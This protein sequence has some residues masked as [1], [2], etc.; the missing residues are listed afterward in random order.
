MTPLDSKTAREMG[1]KSGVVRRRMAEER[2]TAQKQQKRAQKLHREGMTILEAMDL[3]PEFKSESWDAWRTFLKSVF[4]LPL[5][6][7]E[8]ETFVA[9]TRREARKQA[10]NE[11]WVVVGRRGGNSGLLA[12]K[13]AR[14]GTR[15]RN[16]FSKYLGTPLTTVP[17]TPPNVPRTPFHQ[18]QPGRYLT[19]SIE[20]DVVATGFPGPA[21]RLTL[22]T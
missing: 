1:K 16:G 19:V 4:G 18:V 11:A 10:F 22:S 2:K 8:Q 15:T 7:S 9:H 5:S 21:A 12:N 20:R 3:W 6:E 17:A 13:H 14:G